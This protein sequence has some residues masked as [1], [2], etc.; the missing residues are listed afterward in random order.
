MQ[1]NKEQCAWIFLRLSLGLIMLWAFF[2][3]LFGLGFDTCRDVKTGAVQY[4]CDK[5]WLYGGSPTTG[6]L[7]F[8]VHGPFAEIFHK[9]AGSVLIDWLFMLGLL[10]VGLALVLGILN[11]LAG[12]IGALMMLLMYLALLPPQHHPFLDE[13]IIYLIIFLGLAQRPLDQCCGLGK[14]WANTKLVEKNKIFQ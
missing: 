6:F 9:M 10:F 14:W 1:C 7:K 5:A 12:Y 8:G 3:K 2:D 11:K 13:H 4:L